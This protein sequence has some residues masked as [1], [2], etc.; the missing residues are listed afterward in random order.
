MTAPTNQT[1]DAQEKAAETSGLVSCTPRAAARLLS[2]RLLSCLMLV[3][4]FTT[5]T[6]ACS[7]RGTCADTKLPQ[8]HPTRQPEPGAAAASSEDSGAGSAGSTSAV[9]L[10]LL[11][12]RASLCSLGLLSQKVKA[13]EAEL[14]DA[15]GEAAQDK[16]SEA[17]LDARPAQDKSSEAE[18]DARPALSETSMAVPHEASFHLAAAL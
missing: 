16:P 7:V 8:F 2:D 1:Q 12:R 4:K 13:A 14:A 10:L 9:L 5:R 3:A 6:C 11:L 18:L 15:V 17:E